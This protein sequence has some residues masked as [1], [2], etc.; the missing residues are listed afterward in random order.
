MLIVTIT[1]TRPD[2]SVLL[3]LGGNACGDMC[4]DEQTGDGIKEAPTSRSPRALTGFRYLPVVTA[5]IK[6]E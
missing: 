2:G 6:G 1:I 3:R 5:P 4:W